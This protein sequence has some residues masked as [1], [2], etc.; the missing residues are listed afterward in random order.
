MLSGFIPG[1]IKCGINTINMIIAII[2]SKFLNAAALT[3]AKN[4]VFNHQALNVLPI[5]FIISLEFIITGN[6]TNLNIVEKICT[7]LVI[8]GTA[9]VHPRNRP[10]IEIHIPYLLFGSSFQN[11]LT[12]DRKYHIDVI[13]KIN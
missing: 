11:T 10:S 13:K 7:K 2:K 4:I 8:I 5:I 1:G 6:N 12:N 3:I 9:H